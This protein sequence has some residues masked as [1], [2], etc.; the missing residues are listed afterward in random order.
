MNLIQRLLYDN[1]GTSMIEYVIL[2]ALVAAI[3]TLTLVAL[4]N[5]IRAKLQAISSQL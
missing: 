4:F 5:V 1:R 2:A 3:L